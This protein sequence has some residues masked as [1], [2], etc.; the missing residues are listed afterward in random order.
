MEQAD[1][2][3]EQRR[4]SFLQE[5]ARMLGPIYRAN[6]AQGHQWRK[7][8]S[9]ANIPVD[10]ANIFF[11]PDGTDASASAVATCFGCPVRL[12]CLQ[13]ACIAKQRYGIY[14]GLPASIRLQKGS[15]L[16][17]PHE[18]SS[19]AYYDDPYLTEDPKSKFHLD[20]IQPWDGSEDE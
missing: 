18:Y 4:H 7:Q 10:L 13:W 5:E 17:K 8:A 14:G 15:A 1:N 12:Q 16:G 19:L 3:Q 9:C 6:E 11:A 2:G 20:N